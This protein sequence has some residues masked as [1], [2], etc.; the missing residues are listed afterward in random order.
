M[1]SDR[2]RIGG[3]DPRSLISADT[4]K[5][6]AKRRPA[7]RSGAWGV[8]CAWMAST[9]GRRERVSGH[10]QR[11]HLPRPPAHSPPLCFL[12]KALLD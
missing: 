4:W 11:V 9:Y 2:H 6:I 1:L 3:S 5:N 10:E 7:V 8:V 12:L